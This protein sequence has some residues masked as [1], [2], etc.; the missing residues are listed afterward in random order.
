MAGR[1]TRNLIRV[2][3]GTA[4]CMALAACAAMPIPED[5]PAVAV[6][7]PGL[8]RLE[9]ALLIFYGGLLLI[10]PAF[11]GLIRGRLPIEISTRGAKFAEGSDHWI[12]LDEAAVKKLEE[13]AADLTQALTDALVEIDRLS[14]FANGDTTQREVGSKR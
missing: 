4:L 3:T 10:T 11:S 2:L 6:G 1:H 8:Y 12:D 9:V 13:E 7:Q 14:E 5:L